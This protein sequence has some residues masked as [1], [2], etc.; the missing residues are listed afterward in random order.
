MKQ[1]KKRSVGAALLAVILISL[2]F[3]STSP[4]AVSQSATD[5]IANQSLSSDLSLLGADSLNSVCWLGDPKGRF[6]KQFLGT[7]SNPW[8][9]WQEKQRTRLWTDNKSCFETSVEAI[10]LI[11]PVDADVDSLPRQESQKLQ[12]EASELL[13][14]TGRGKDL[15]KSN[16]TFILQTGAQL[17]VFSRKGS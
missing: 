3:F 8:V 4:Q 17:L 10:V 9:R 12:A 16:S 2:G 11:F 15:Q 5:I 13:S 7:S 1:N 14:Q 6:L